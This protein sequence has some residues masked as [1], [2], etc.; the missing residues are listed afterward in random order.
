MVFDAVL[1]SPVTAGMEEREV[2][3]QECLV[4]NKKECSL[5]GKAD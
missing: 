3:Y 5:P 2:A 4:L 1:D